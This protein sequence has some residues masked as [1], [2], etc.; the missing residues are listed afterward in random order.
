MSK[1]YKIY[2]RISDG[3]YAE[4]GRDY[5][6]Y[7]AIQRHKVAVHNAKA[8]GDLRLSYKQPTY[9]DNGER[10][11]SALVETLVSDD[12]IHIDLWETWIDSHGNPAERFLHKV[13][14]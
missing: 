7:D 1:L 10:T 6:K 9:N 12:K 3:L 4:I 13:T 11:G 5:S 2:A 8:H 14:I